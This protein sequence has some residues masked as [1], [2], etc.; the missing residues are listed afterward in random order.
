MI[1]TTDK[2]RKGIWIYSSCFNEHHWVYMSFFSSSRGV[3]ERDREAAPGL[4]AAEPQDVS[5]RCCCFWPWAAATGARR[6]RAHE[7]ANPCLSASC[8]VRRIINM[9]GTLHHDFFSDSVDVFFFSFFFLLLFSSYSYS[10]ID[11]CINSLY[12]NLDLVYCAN[13]GKVIRENW[14]VM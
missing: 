12:V 1:L 14:S 11:M 3:E 2:V 6:E 5:R 10:S 4:R 8:A 13:C 7:L 9:E